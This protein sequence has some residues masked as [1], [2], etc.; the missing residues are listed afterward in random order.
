MDIGLIGIGIS[1]CFFV[2][3]RATIALHVG[4][5]KNKLV[6]KYNQNIILSRFYEY[7]DGKL[8]YGNAVQEMSEHII[9]LHKWTFKQFYPNGIDSIKEEQNVY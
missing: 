6:Y 3:V 1:I 7:P 4:S 2:F 9:S 5:K 8:S